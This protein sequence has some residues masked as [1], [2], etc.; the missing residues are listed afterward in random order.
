MYWKVK[1]DVPRF[2]PTN[3][4]I[5]DSDFQNGTD[6][7]QLRGSTPWFI[8]EVPPAL[9]AW[10][11]ELYS[12]RRYLIEKDRLPCIEGSVGRVLLLTGPFFF[13]VPRKWLGRNFTDASSRGYIQLLCLGVSP[14]PDHRSCWPPGASLCAHCF[15]I[16]LWQ[17]GSWIKRRIIP[18]HFFWLGWLIQHLKA[19]V[20]YEYFPPPASP[21]KM[22][23]R[24]S[25]LLRICL[26]YTFHSVIPGSLVYPPVFDSLILGSSQDQFSQLFSSLLPLH[27]AE[28]KYS[29]L[30]TD[31]LLLFMSNYWGMPQLTD[32]KRLGVVADCFEFLV[33][34]IADSSSL[35]PAKF[36]DRHGVVHKASFVASV[37]CW[38]RIDWLAATQV[39]FFHIHFLS[40]PAV[41]PSL[42]P[43]VGSRQP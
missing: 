42:S 14:E 33:S 7:R 3:V 31:V 21:S 27:E 35:M 6:F 29:V 37:S 22:D 40:Y 34:L 36:K 4:L 41:E 23:K 24:V 25:K 16:V 11:F 18:C 12:W 26:T 10:V 5:S 1:D 13:K 9:S 39:L 43:P 30:Q 32:R 20:A 2:P 19:A 28:L 17:H 38:R 15:S 8:E